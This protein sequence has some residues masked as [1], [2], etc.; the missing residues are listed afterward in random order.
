MDA[1]VVFMSGMIDSHSYGFFTRMSAPFD[2]NKQATRHAELT[3]HH[4]SPQVLLHGIYQ[5]T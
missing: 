2:S 3:T 1:V 5:F 4:F